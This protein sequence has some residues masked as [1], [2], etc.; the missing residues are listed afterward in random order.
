M[1]I[2]KNLKTDKTGGINI[3][4]DSYIALFLGIVDLGNQQT[5]Y[6]GVKTIKQQAA[7]TFELQDFLI[8]ENQQPARV[9][10]I[11][12]ISMKSKATLPDII[13][14]LGGDPDSEEGFDFEKAVG[15]PVLLQM[16]D[17]QTKTKVVP[18][19]ISALPSA[20]KSSVK[21]LTNT[22]LVEL[23]VEA[24]SETQL[25]NLPD[26]LQKIINGRIQDHSN[27]PSGSSAVDL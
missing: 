2:S 27:T 1:A 21:P 13:R 25:S 14:A 19:V 18:G 4:V 22:P 9:T 20:F 15:K 3:P 5:E 7:L 11:V 24:L 16:K 12:T 17:N 10:K 6:Q 23:D 26:W 8:G